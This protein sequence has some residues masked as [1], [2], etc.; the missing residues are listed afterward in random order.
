M[1]A[2]LEQ[3]QAALLQVQ[4]DKDAWE[5]HAKEITAD[6]QT[7]KTQLQEDLNAARS[8]IQELTILLKRADDD[9]LRIEHKNGEL[10]RHVCGWDTVANSCAVRQAA[11]RGAR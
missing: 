8:Q 1:T 9:V 11:R 4:E 3:S 2:K 5:A 10:Q 6:H 7:E